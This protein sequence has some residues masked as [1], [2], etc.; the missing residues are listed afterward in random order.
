[1]DFSNYAPYCWARKDAVGK[2]E[3]GNWGDGYVNTLNR[4]A[5]PGDPVGLYASG[6]L[7][8]NGTITLA[9]FSVM[10][11]VRLDVAPGSQGDLNFVL[12]GSGGEVLSRTGIPV[13]FSEMAMPPATGTVLL[14]STAFANIIEWKEGVTSIEVQDRAGNVLAVRTV[15]EGSPS[16]SV[17]SP[18]GGEVWKA[19]TPATV[20]WT[21]EDPDGDPLTISV[22]VSA[23]AGKTWI[24]VAA[25]LTGSEFTFDTTG[26]PPAQQAVVKV[27]VSDGV[28][29][30][31]SLSARPFTIQSDETKP[32]GAGYGS[33]MVFLCFASVAGAYL[34]FRR[35][36]Q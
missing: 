3:G 30:A 18:A 24:P 14:D 22:L 31:E 4:L 32:A 1:M 29:T 2:T 7:Y 11:N 34:I 36:R 28:N 19:G 12:K 25:G 8:S 13:T 15:S 6:T 21:A 10:E 16:V 23:D 17:I 20:S 27:R 5:D 35:G 9:P 26:L 33:G